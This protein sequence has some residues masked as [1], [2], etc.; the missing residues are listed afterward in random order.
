MLRSAPT[1]RSALSR[2]QPNV[3]ALAAFA[4]FAIWA[5]ATVGIDVVLW[6]KRW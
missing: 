6:S 2:N 3:I 1:R 4:L 5:A